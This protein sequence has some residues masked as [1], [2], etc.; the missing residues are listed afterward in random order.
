M[1]DD[2]VRWFDAGFG[3]EPLTASLRV[4]GLTSLGGPDLVGDD[5]VTSG[6]SVLARC[7]PHMTQLGALELR[8]CRLTTTCVR[9]IGT[10]LPASLESLDLRGNGMIAGTKAEVASLLPGMSIVPG[11]FRMFIK[12]LKVSRRPVT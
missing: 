8:G 9:A 1:W 10:C 3:C 2:V 4:L 12:R 6:S 5:Y 7:L 11:E